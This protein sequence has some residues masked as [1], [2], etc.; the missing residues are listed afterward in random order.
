MESEKQQND[1]L[2]VLMDM[3]DGA[4]ASD[5]NEK[6]NELLQ[7]VFDTAAKGEM[8]I[9]LSV[10]P[11]KMGLGGIVLEVTA[12]HKVKL[13]KPELPV[14]KA[15]FFVSKEGRLTRDN[16]AQTQMFELKEKE[17]TKRG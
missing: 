3:R 5:L 12:E 17:E 16:P 7:A 6:F 11:A 14:G 15:M 8:S 4:V 13:K 2:S 1:L 10:E 9:T